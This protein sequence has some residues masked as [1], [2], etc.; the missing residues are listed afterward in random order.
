MSHEKYERALIQF[1]EDILSII[2]MFEEKHSL[3]LRRV[4]ARI[5]GERY[6]IA[7]DAQGNRWG[8]NKDT[9]EDVQRFKA[10]VT[11]KMAL[12]WFKWRIE[13]IVVIFDVR[14]GGVLFEVK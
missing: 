12:F 4:R 1:R 2:L 6:S 7:V 5:N 9:L 3:Y 11:D 13:R 10:W 14:H 8:D